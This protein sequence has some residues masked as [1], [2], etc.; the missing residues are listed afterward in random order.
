MYCILIVIALVFIIYFF[1]PEKSLNEND[2]FR[3]KADEFIV[4]LTHYKSDPHIKNILDHYKGNLKYYK[5]NGE[6]AGFIMGNGTLLGICSVD[7]DG[8]KLTV[9][10]MLFIFLHEISHCACQ[11]YE[12]NKEFWEVFKKIEDISKEIDLINFDTLTK[13][14]CSVDFVRP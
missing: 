4:Y 6:F 7:G 12:H 8:K 3:R 2:I 1:L 13:E 11:H 14:A 9:N 5:D 10:D